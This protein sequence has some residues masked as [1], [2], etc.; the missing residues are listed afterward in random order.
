MISTKTL[1][2]IETVDFNEYNFLNAYDKNV[3]SKKQTIPLNIDNLSYKIKIAQTEDTIL[4]KYSII[5][6]QKGKQSQKI[7]MLVKNKKLVKHLLSKVS[8]QKTLKLTECLWKEI[9]IKLQKTIQTQGAKVNKV[10]DSL[11]QIEIWIGKQE[12]QLEAKKLKSQIW[13]KADECA[14]ELLTKKIDLEEEMLLSGLTAVE[15]ELIKL[16]SAGI[17]NVRDFLQRAKSL[18]M[19]ATIIGLHHKNIISGVKEALK[20]KDYRDAYFRLFNNF[21]ARDDFLERLIAED[22]PVIFLVPRKLFGPK[23]GVTAE[24]MRWLLKNFT[25][26]KNVHFVFG[27]Y[28][29]YSQKIIPFVSDIHELE[30]YTECLTARLFKQVQANLSLAP[31]ES[32]EEDEKELEFLNNQFEEINAQVHPFHVSLINQKG[33]T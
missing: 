19:E 7:R 27:A 18:P 24:E 5:V 25:Q 30:H 3:F 17:Y 8:E 6:I 32:F 15:I 11:D 9:F 31:S 28:Q 23:Q 10:L 22:K 2:L 21:F 13:I 14:K 20:C 29:S 26:M 4:K 33:P 1:R 12:L 16:H